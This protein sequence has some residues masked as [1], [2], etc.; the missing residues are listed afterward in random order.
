MFK[1]LGMP[2]VQIDSFKLQELN[3][4]RITLWPLQKHQS[5]K[6][7]ALNPP[8]NAAFGDYATV[9]MITHNLYQNDE[10]FIDFSLILSTSK[11]WLLV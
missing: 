11:E 9:W 4:Q 1:L 2:H 8:N 3:R 10:L 5:A 6:I 7:L